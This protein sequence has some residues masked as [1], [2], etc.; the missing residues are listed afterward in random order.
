MWQVS[1]TGGTEPRW[2]HSGRELFFRNEAGEFVVVSVTAAATFEWGEPRSLFSMQAYR[3][4][5]NGR[6]W[7][8]APGDQ[9]VLM[10]RLITS[11]TPSELIVVQNFFEELKAKEQR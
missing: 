11:D 6:M 3:T 10:L 1:T 9:R 2:A 8:V 5:N 4:A 7:D